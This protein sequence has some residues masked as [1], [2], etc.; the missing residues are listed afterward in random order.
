MLL[1]VIEFKILENYE[2]L[3]T[4]ENKEVKKFSFKHLLNEKPFHL[5]EDPNLFNRVF[6]QYGTLCWPNDIDIAPEYLY[7]HSV[8]TEAAS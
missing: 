1:D 6:L 7:N 2:I 8:K 3:I 4:F 5:L